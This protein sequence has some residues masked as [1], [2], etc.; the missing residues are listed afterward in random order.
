M[1][2]TVF[3]S[4]Y[5]I[6]STAGLLLLKKSLNNYEFTSMQSY[7]NVLLSYKFIL[8]F[9]LYASSFI[10]WLLILNKKELSFIY[11]IVIGLSYILIMLIAVFVLKE[12]FTL[13]KSIGA[14]LI[15]AGI[16]IMFLQ[17]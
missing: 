2:L 17:K 1:N 7:F 12:S 15:G 16:I 9:L 11:P 13:S 6:F 8:G 14:I 10:V 4:I 3:I 5:L